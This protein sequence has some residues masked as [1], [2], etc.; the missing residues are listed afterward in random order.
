[1]ILFFVIL[2]LF[3]FIKRKKIRMQKILYPALYFL[4]YRTKIGLNFM[5]NVAKKFPRFLRAAGYF[6]IFIGFSGM[7]L[8]AFELI[9]NLVK[10]LT[11]PEAV[12]GVGLVLPFEVKGA[13][14]VPFF[15]WIISIF[16]LAVVHEFSH[17]IFARLYDIKIKSSGFAVLAILIPIL[18]AAFV[19][20]DEKKLR[21]KK[22]REQL[23]VF[24]AGPFANIAFAF[25]VLLIFGLFVPP[26][27]SSIVEL[28]GIEVVEIL[29]NFPAQKAG[30]TKGEIIKEIDNVE[31]K[32]LANFTSFLSSKRPGDSVLLKTDKNEYN[33]VLGEN[34]QNKSKS[35]LGVSVSQNSDIK[36]GV[37]E[38]YGKLIPSVILWFIGL[39][40]WL[41]LLNLGIGLFNLVPIGPI[42][43]GR[44]M[45]VALLKFFNKKKADRYWKIISVFFLLL[46]IFNVGVAF[47][48]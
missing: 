3:A 33:I 7:L 38:K 25:F 20:P 42:D 14:Y 22:A 26:V 31:V 47:V 43:G 18:P 21:K 4:M 5:D 11:T 15:Y 46:I 41:Y 13:F 17:G 12:P 34:P 45:H 9:R 32:G 29:D 44:M 37:I 16:I 36:G 1:M 48:M 35:Y 40:Y 19:E 27:L 10:I 23:S 8:L 24:A 28:N 30:I 39:M 6:A 2:S